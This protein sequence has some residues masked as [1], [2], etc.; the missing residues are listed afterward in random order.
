MNAQAVAKQGQ[1]GNRGLAFI[2]K[3]YK[4]EAECR[5]FTHDERKRYRDEHARPILT[6]FRVWIDEAVHKTPPKGAAGKA[7]L[8]AYR[9]REYVVRYLDDGRFEIDNGFAE[10]QIRPFAVGRKNWLFS[11]TEK[12]AEASANLYSLLVTAKINGLNP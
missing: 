5:E 7:L 12:G 6:A 8:Y 11:D 10:N 9:E 1:I 3:L 4:V 2:K